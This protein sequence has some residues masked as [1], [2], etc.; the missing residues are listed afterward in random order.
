[1]EARAERYPLLASFWCCSLFYLSGQ[2]GVSRLLGELQDN[3]I[4]IVCFAIVMS[5]SLLHLDKNNINVLI[6]RC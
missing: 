3:G 5:G 6:G 1:M 2:Y 4:G